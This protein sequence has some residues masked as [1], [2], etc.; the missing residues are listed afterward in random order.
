MKLQI[1]QSVRV[2]KGTL[3][4]DDADFDISG[5]QGRIFEISDE[6]GKTLIGVSWD[7]ITMREMPDRYIQKSEMEGLDWE[8][9]YL[10]DSDIEPAEA[11]D[12]EKDAETTSKKRGKP[13]E[14]LS[15]GEEGQRIQAVVNSADSD[16][17]LDIME[18]WEKHLN[19]QLR[20]PVQC[21]VDEF[22]ERGPLTYG[23]QLV[24]TGIDSV[25]ETYG[26]MVKCKKLIG[27]RLFPLCDLAAQD[28]KSDNAR[29]IEDYRTWFANRQY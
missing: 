15:M 25:D 28:K 10:Y 19:Q 11:R 14:W 3:C 21:V 18:A 29:H 26:V 17:D 13:F 12:A 1:D 9:M 5:W 7:S 16:D 4:P 22:Q 27:G 24:V 23:D 6:D 2:K 8:T 20:F